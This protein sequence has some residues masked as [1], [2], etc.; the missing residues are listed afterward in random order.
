MCSEAVYDL[1]QGK[2]PRWCEE[3]CSGRSP[4]EHRTEGDINLS[5]NDG[6]IRPIHRV[7]DSLLI[8]AAPRTKAVAN[9]IRRGLLSSP[10]PCGLSHL[11]FP[12]CLHTGLLPG[13]GRA[14]VKH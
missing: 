12:P 5:V 4:Q 1:P 8:T 6:L 2:M 14:L 10:L 9:E 13:G 3:G 7:S 11:P